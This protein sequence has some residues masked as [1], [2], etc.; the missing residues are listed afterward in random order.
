MNHLIILTLSVTTMRIMSTAIVVADA[1]TS[2]RERKTMP[3]FE[4]TFRRPEAVGVETIE[5]DNAGD[6]E[7]EVLDNLDY[8]L[9]INQAEQTTADATEV[10]EK[11]RKH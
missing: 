6:A 10:N 8:Y 11:E 4:V 9:S 7:E 3:K 5:A 1:V 2:K